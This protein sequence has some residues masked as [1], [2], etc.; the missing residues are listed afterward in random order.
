MCGTGGGGGAAATQLYIAAPV[1]GDGTG[2]AA[3]TGTGAGVAAAAGPAT[4]FLLRLLVL[5][6]RAPTTTKPVLGDSSK[7]TFLLPKEDAT[8][9]SVGGGEGVTPPFMR[10]AALARTD[11]RIF[12]RELQTG[13]PLPIVS[14]A[15]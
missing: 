12:S 4:L 10:L 11:P 15:S 2:T 3:G 5:R 9:T 14:S 6:P 13:S 7:A 8:P 1:G